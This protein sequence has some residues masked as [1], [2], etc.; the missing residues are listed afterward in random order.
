MLTEAD[1]IRTGRLITVMLLGQSPTRCDEI[2]EIGHYPGTGIT[3]ARIFLRE[4]RKPGMEN[5]YCIQGVGKIWSL[6]R[7]ILDNF[8]N[9]VE[10]FINNHFVRKIRVKDSSGH[11]WYNMH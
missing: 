4:G 8:S 7:V 11:G 2:Q 9:T 5:M 10:I 3:P 6:N 1:A